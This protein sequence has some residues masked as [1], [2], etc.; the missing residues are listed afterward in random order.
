MVFDHCLRLHNVTMSR[1]F[2]SGNIN[3]FRGCHALRIIALEF[4]EEITGDIEDIER[5]LPQC[6]IQV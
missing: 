6:R 5:A 4:C 2:V 1:T 3:A